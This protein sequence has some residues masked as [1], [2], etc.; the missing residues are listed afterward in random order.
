[1]EDRTENCGSWLPKDKKD[2]MW[3]GMGKFCGLWPPAFPRSQENRDSEKNVKK[4]K[5]KFM[6][7]NLRMFSSQFNPS[8]LII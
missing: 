2:N 3:H 1:M 5:K 7:S 6:F 4:I 8:Q